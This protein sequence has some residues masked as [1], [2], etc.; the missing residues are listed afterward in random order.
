MLD[1][2]LATTLDTA[3]TVHLL[4]EKKI[5]IQFKAEIHIDLNFPRPKE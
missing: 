1:G 2:R 5:D 4:T 3:I